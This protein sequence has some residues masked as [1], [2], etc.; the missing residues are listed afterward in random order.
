MTQNEM[1]MRLA[2]TRM[3]REAFFEGFG[4][5]NVAAKSWLDYA[6]NT[7]DWDKFEKL[8]EVFEDNE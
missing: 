4:C 2:V 1:E 5:L 3:L 6:P 7:A 8:L